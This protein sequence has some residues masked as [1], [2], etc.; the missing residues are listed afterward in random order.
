M[1]HPFIEDKL[2]K[3]EIRE[4]SNLKAL[5]YEINYAQQ[6]VKYDPI[7]KKWFESQK[8]E[9]G[10]NGIAFYSRDSKLFFYLIN[11]EELREAVSR[12]SDIGQFCEFCGEIRFSYLCC[13]KGGIKEMILDIYLSGKYNCR[14]C[15]DVLKLSPFLFQIYFFVWVSAVLF[16]ERRKPI[17]ERLYDSYLYEKQCLLYFYYTICFLIGLISCFIF[18]IPYTL[19]YIISIIIIFIHIYKKDPNYTFK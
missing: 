1:E 4:K 18:F 10:E 12:Y 17:V 6:K 5:N 3:F 15:V 13:I 16:F 9:R 14:D 2:D 11:E 8:R 19:L 7:F